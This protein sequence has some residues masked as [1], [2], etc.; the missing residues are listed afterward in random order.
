MSGTRAALDRLPDVAKG[1]GARRVLPL[2]V[3]GAFHSPLVAAAQAPLRE[4]LERTAWHTPSPAFFSACSVEFESA[5]FVSLLVRQIV[6]PVRFTQAVNGLCAAGYDAYL[7]VGPGSVL[8]GLV[9]RIAPDAK[10]SQAGDVD[11][12]DAFLE[13]GHYVEAE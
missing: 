12:I 13:D 11:S 2:A 7:E 5:D 9:K 3:S 8:S 1:A 6:S 4:E 10:V